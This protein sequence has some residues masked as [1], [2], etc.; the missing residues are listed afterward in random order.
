MAQDGPSL[1]WNRRQLLRAATVGSAAFAVDP[2]IAVAEGGSW[3]CCDGDDPVGCIRAHKF[4]V[5]VAFVCAQLHSLWGG[6]PGDS[7]AAVADA[8]LQYVEYLDHPLQRGVCG[9]L[10]WINFYSIRHMGKGFARLTVGENLFVADASIFPAGCEI[11]PQLTIMTL[12]MYAAD[13]LLARA[14]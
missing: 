6:P 14:A 12:A 7:S 11:N 9:T 10:T 8:V 4:E 13:S 3:S 1:L 5:L 2:S